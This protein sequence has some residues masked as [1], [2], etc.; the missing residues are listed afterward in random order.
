MHKG[1]W[2]ALG[3]LLGAVVVVTFWASPAHSQKPPAAPPPQPGFVPRPQPKEET[4]IQ[5]VAR[6]AKTGEEESKRVFDALGPAIRA[7]LARG[8]EV[9]I[10]GLGTFRVVRVAEHRDLRGGRPVMVPASNTVEFLAAGEIAEAANTEGAV[11]AD[12]VPPFQYIVLPNQ[13]P[14]QKMPNVRTPG[15]RVP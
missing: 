3:T 2:L 4:L 15:I 11:P 12:V 8:K 10:P 7:E 1:K 6:E 5:R 14:G 13:T 9:T